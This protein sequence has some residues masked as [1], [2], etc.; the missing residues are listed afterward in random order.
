[1]TGDAEFERI[2]DN[3]ARALKEAPHA[4]REL[5]AATD[6]TY[7]YIEEAGEALPDAQYLELKMLASQAESILTRYFGM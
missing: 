4:Q 6:A 2:R 3:L 1:M 7:D 5:L